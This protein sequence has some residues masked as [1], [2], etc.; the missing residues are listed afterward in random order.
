MQQRI[1]RELADDVD[2]EF[3]MELDDDR[4]GRLLSEADLARRMNA[5]RSRLEAS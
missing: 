5:V 4:L 2:E 3:E 1:E